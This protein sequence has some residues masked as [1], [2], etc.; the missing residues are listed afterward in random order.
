MAGDRFRLEVKERERLGS[1]ESRRLRRQ[2][3]VPGVLYGKSAA[4]AFVVEAPGELPPVEA[5]PDLLEEVLR[6]L[7][8][9]A[10]KYAPG[11]GS[12]RTVVARDGEGIAIR[13]SDEGIGIAPEHVGAVFERFRRVGGD[14]T[15]RGMGLGLYLSRSLVEAQGGRITASSPGP[16][17]GATFTITLP[18]AA[19]WTEAE[20]P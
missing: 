8:E 7:Y 12:V 14:P 3:L 1:P 2:G 11:G 5:D 6:N 18:V 20:E 4:H 13:V 10:V 19:G 16:G 17:R 9:N 15:V